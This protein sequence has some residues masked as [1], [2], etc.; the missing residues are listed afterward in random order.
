MSSSSSSRRLEYFELLDIPEDCSNR[1]VV[2]AYRRKSLQ[3]HPDKPGGDKAIFQKLTK[4]YACLRNEGKRSRYLRLGYDE[5]NVTGEEAGEGGDYSAAT[6]V[7]AF[8]GESARA[9]DG[10]SADWKL[11]SVSNYTIISLEEV[12]IYMRDIV[13]VGLNYLASVDIP[14][15]QESFKSIFLLRHSRI[16]ILYL[17]LGLVED[18]ELTQEAFDR[19]SSYPITYYDTPLQPGIAPRWSDQN[20]LGNDRPKDIEKRVERKELNYEEFERRQRFALAALENNVDE[21]A[22]LEEDYYTK[23]TEGEQQKSSGTSGAGTT[24]GGKYTKVERLEEDAEAADT[25]DG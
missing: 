14:L 5:D 2:Q 19:D 1:Q 20:I 7:D 13:Q 21:L 3:H 15:G 8:F 18:E 9:A 11:F 24:G 17:M 25:F 22:A 6:F 10:R 23:K 12:P 4:A 16:D